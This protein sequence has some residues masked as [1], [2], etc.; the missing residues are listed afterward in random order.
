M[1]HKGFFGAEKGVFLAP[2]RSGPKSFACGAKKSRLRRDLAIL[3]ANAAK[4]KG[5]FYDTK[6]ATKKTSEKGVS[7]AL[8][9]NKGFF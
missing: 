3:R 1:L 2:Q 5:K 8:G 6:N 9:L 4:N 7:L